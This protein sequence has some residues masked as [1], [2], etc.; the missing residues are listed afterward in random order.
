MN[1]I[2]VFTPTYNRATLLSRL[3]ES[4]KR[5]T[6]KNFEWLVVDDGS[7]DNTKELI[8]KWMEVSEINI[9]YIYKDNGGKMR[10]HN[11]GV[12]ECKTELFM[13]L[14]SDDY[15]T[16][17]CIDSIYSNWSKYSKYKVGKR[18]SGMVAYRKMNGLK[19]Y[20]FPPKEYATLQ[21]IN[22]VY[23]G[24]TALAFRT[25]ILKDNLFPEIEDEKF[26]GE[27]VVY[28]KLDSMYFLV[29]VPE[30]WI[31]CEYQEGGLT[32][33][34]LRL[35]INNPKGWALNA[36]T[37]YI[38]SAKTLKDKFKYSSTYVCASLVA[39]KNVCD[40]IYEFPNKFLCLLC[41]PIGIIQKIKNEQ[42]NK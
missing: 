20:Y 3:Y 14:D 7:S 41:F 15:L 36:K 13:C 16:D 35:L 37:K 10:A 30:Y 6:N 18:I 8:H 23:K 17:G 31:E 5:Q 25:E 12:K 1:L 42:F 24:E 32:D 22:K 39:R 28:D 2:T 26:I 4:L 29:V 40:I 19:P 33:S 9:R 27:G 21:E 34:A 11:V 38:Y